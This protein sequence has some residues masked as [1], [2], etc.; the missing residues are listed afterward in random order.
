MTDN[1]TITIMAVGD[2]MLG[3]TPHSYGFGVGSLI[4]KFGP[5]YPFINCSA[6]LRDADIIFCNL[7]VVL[8]RFNR[9]TAPFDEIV[10][11]AQPEAAGGLAGAGFNIVSLANNHIMQH[12]ADAVKETVGILS[13]YGIKTIGLNI[14][15]KDIAN[16]AIININGIRIGFLAYNLR[17]RQYF[18]DPPLYIRGEREI[19]SKDITG[20][21]PYTDF[22]VISLHWGDEF[23]NYPSKVQMDLAH[24]IID[25]G[26]NI[27]LGHHPHIIQGIES[28]KK[29]VIAYSL[30]N[31]IFD[32]WQE[33]L[34]NTFVLKLILEKSGNIRYDIIPMLI[35][36]R[37]QPQIARGDRA[38]KIRNHVNNQ[39]MIHHPENNDNYDQTLQ[40]EL[41]R[42]RREIYWHYLTHLHKY[43]FGRLIANFMGAVKRRLN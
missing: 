23:I 10:L 42:Y 6:A 1:S 21:K 3:D 32:M 30:G 20:L 24:F 15:D 26:A 28:Y 19:I 36:S 7:E 40:K 5:E 33:R 43:D 22:I 17:P 41:R 39:S 13:G 14:P 35:N 4:E 25:S 37:F 34:R 2:V 9:A 27:I 8:S 18:L 29:G 16:H 12:G 11:R 31:F 38:A